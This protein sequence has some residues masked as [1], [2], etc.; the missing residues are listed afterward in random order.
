MP[1]KNVEPVRR[2]AERAEPII[3]PARGKQLFDWDDMGLGLECPLSSSAS[4]YSDSSSDQREFEIKPVATKRKNNVDRG[5]FEWVRNLIDC[6]KIKNQRATLDDHAFRTTGKGWLHDQ[7]KALDENSIP[8]TFKCILAASGVSKIFNRCR[9]DFKKPEYRSRYWSWS[10]NFILLLDYFID[11]G[12]IKVTEKVSRKYQPLLSFLETCKEHKKE[13][14]LTTQKEQLLTALG[15]VWLKEASS[16]DEVYVS[17]DDS[18]DGDSQGDETWEMPTKHRSSRRPKTVSQRRR[19]KKRARGSSSGEALPLDSRDE[20]PPPY[21]TPIM[22]TPRS[23]KTWAQQ[24]L[25]VRRHYRKQRGE[26]DLYDVPS[27]QLS[28]RIWMNAETARCSTGTLSQICCAILKA[29]EMASS[30]D[31]GLLDPESEL[32]AKGFVAFLDYVIRQ[33]QPREEAVNFLCACRRAV[34]R[35]TLST[36]HDALL[37]GVIENW[38]ESQEMKTC[39]RIREDAR[40]QQLANPKRLGSGHIL[41][42]ADLDGHVSDE[43][44]GHVVEVVLDSG[45]YNIDEK[46]DRTKRRRTAKLVRQ[47]LSSMI[48]GEVAINVEGRNPTAAERNAK[49]WVL[50]AGA[51]D[52]DVYARNWFRAANSYK[53]GNVLV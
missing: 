41:D 2:S 28:L 38:F 16:D 18:F 20:S 11:H 23:L 36:D 27:D 9:D 47:N 51:K 5:T 12:N 39:V 35:G 30:E 14:I 21:R 8:V 46:F 45:T 7:H 10:V 25:R 13:G 43:F 17:D 31:V 15:I 49:E 34:F 29:A 1:R 50:R 44:N 22:Q 26:D 3:V 4:V 6:R 40:Q 37:R 53:H 32:W 52:F 24:M 48:E 33:K 42:L 19:S